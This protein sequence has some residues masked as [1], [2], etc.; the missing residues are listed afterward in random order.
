LLLF[1]DWAFIQGGGR[2][3][4]GAG[5]QFGIRNL[6]LS[7]IQVFVGYGFNPNGYATTVS[8]GQKF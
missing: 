2:T 4:V 6:L 1:T 5:A 8:I 7:A 3:A